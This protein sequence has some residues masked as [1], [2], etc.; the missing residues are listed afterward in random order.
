AVTYTGTMPVAFNGDEFVVN[1]TVT[2]D[3]LVDDNS[4]AL[5][6]RI[7][8]I[9]GATDWS[10][11]IVIASKTNVRTGT[12]TY[13]ATFSGVE[14][15]HTPTTLFNGMVD[16]RFQVSDRA[17]ETPNTSSY[18]VTNVMY[19]TT[20]PGVLITG[21][22]GQGVTEVNLVT[23]IPLATTAT[24]EASAWDVLFGQIN[25]IASGIEKLEF[26][27]TNNVT[28]IEVL[29]GTV[30]AAP[31]SMAWNTTGLEVGSYDVNVTAYDNAGNMNTVSQTVALVPPITWQ[32]Y[33]LVTAMNFD[34]DL[35]NQDKLYAH[36][37]TWNNELIE[38]VS[39][40]YTT[41]GTVW[42]QFAAVPFTPATMT[43]PTPV[44]AQFNAE[45]MTGVTQIRTVVTYNGGQVSAN[46]PVLAVTYNAANG[47]S[48]VATA[49]AITPN[50]FYKNELRIV[51]AV[52]LPVITEVTDGTYVGTLPVQT[53]NGNTTA[54]INIPNP[55]EYIY[56]ASSIN[57]NTW[58]MQLNST[59][60]NT[61]NIGS[62]TNN[63]ITITAP[64]NGFVYFQNVM[65]IM[66]LPAGFSALSAQ[67]AV[68]AKQNNALINSDLTVTL[69]A[70]PAAQGTVVAM[71][72]DEVAGTW[73][74]PINVTTN[75][76]GTVSFNAPTGHIVA[77]TQYTGVTINA[78]F[79]SIT[80]QYLAP[81]TNLWTKDNPY[82]E[83]FVYEGMDTNGYIL[84]LTISEVKLYL[85]GVMVTP[86]AA[87][88]NATGI[89]GYQANALTAGM[90]TVRL[91]V[92][93]NGFTAMAEK[94]FH[95][96]TTNPVITTH[97][98]QI[99]STN[100]IVSATIVDPETGIDTVALTV[101]T[102]SV[103][104]SSLTVTGNTYTYLITDEDLLTL[105][106]NFSTTMPLSVNWTA[107]NHLPNMQGAA[108]ADYT[109]NIV[110]PGI[111]F[112][113]F[114]NG[115]W[116]NPTA[117]TP[118]T[119][120]VIAPEGRT[121]QDN[122][123]V[124]LEEM[125][126]DPVNGNYTNTIQSMMLNPISVAGNVY[127]Y[128]LNF[129]YAVA[130]NAHAVLLHVNAVDSYNVTS[131]SHQTYG[132]D[133]LAPV[134]W[135]LAPVGA[136]INPDTFPVV[137]ESAVLPFGTNVA[138]GVGFQDIQGFTTLETGE[139]WLDA[140]AGTWHND[141]LVYYTAA[142]GI[143]GNAT[144]VMVT[145]DGTPVTNGTITNGSFTAN[146]GTLPAGNHTVIA[147][148]KDNAGNVGSLSYTFTITGGAPTITF[149]PLTGGGWWLN[150]TNDNTLGFSVTTT[151]LLA[152]GGVIANIYTVPGNTLLQ[153][154][155]TPTPAGTQYSISL[156]GGVIPADQTGI[157]LEVAATDVW[158][159][160]ST[161]TQV[162]GIDNSVPAITLTSPA[163]DA[164]FVMGATVNILASITDQLAT[165]AASQLTARHDSRM[166]RSGSG[167]QSVKLSVVAP[168][169]EYAFDPITYPANTQVVMKSML[170]AQYGT[171]M[172]NLIATDGAGNQAMV[173]RNFM[174]TPAS[175]PAVSFNEIAGGWLN[176][177]TINH[178]GFTVT[179]PVAVTV[180]A[181]VY[182]YPSE[183]ML[184]GPLTV[185][186][187]DGVYTVNLNGAM[188][189][190][191]QTSV[192][193]QVM[194][195]DIFGNI[196]EA[197]NYYSVDKYAPVITILSPAEGAEFTLVDETT[198]VRIEA[199]FSDMAA[200]L[201]NTTGSGIAASR[202]V[203]IDPMGTQV[204]A[205]IETGAGINETM[206]EINNLILG[207]YTARV[208]V[209]DI[210]GNQ[211][212]ASVIFT[213]IAAPLPPVE[214]EIS[215]AHAYP[216]PMTTETGA[217][218]S[219]SLSTASTVTVRVYDFAG[220]EVRTMENAGRA[221]GKTKLVIAFDGRTN[222]GV[223][224]ARGTYFARVI[225]NDGKKIV[226]KIV[227]IA[228]KK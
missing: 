29:I 187:V 89:I 111:V 73:S 22:T 148:V 144:N 104:M 122:L 127:S 42:T 168:D 150:S 94:V 92:T 117:N 33:A 85:D 43:P 120:N 87:Y 195:T 224:L 5:Q 72:Y 128:S 21:I 56:W 16:F 210:A 6:A 13:V 103:P 136:P 34:G 4:I 78:M 50:V 185:N 180:S 116:I 1:Y 202:M 205:A 123:S 218:F 118:L 201:K 24:I 126:N 147:T 69:N 139:W 158:G 149:N 206:T 66:T 62:V 19:D 68:F 174:V 161:S 9:D 171:Y 192:R 7:I 196:V 157:R 48:L 154:P 166:D 90:H 71:W 114:A 25:Q 208:T 51:G 76:N 194:V 225:A 197:N 18:I 65:P 60:L 38:A 101:G 152:Q 221:D 8:G 105:G 15:Y 133:Y 102:I 199:Q 109:V 12:N 211:A 119:F 91:L 209:W 204:G 170:A 146:A 26:S 49:P 200:M 191:D 215:D 47:G 106:Y 175:G 182:T 99:T 124:T 32:P 214:L 169:G 63:G 160:T 228:I 178:L 31:Y 115:W 52:N 159:G 96:D 203:V 28:G 46:K 54:F 181:N 100:R 189:P 188:I 95:V 70:T 153:G 110:A 108:S 64:A 98:S 93:Q 184:M 79:R 39:F 140:V 223:K 37:D 84:P 59:T 132:I 130:P 17:E 27:Y 88:N 226:E 137:Y 53:V 57:Y 217:N 220:R 129:G 86:T 162:Y 113:G 61:T 67:H 176:S 11:P 193:L 97:G 173:S 138:L 40:E 145:L 125:I 35:A 10:R 3:D 213:V 216:N 227:K 20:D 198:K 135:A 44:V 2:S 55:G 142:S 41:N 156:L 107:N 186:P 81:T 121:I 172:I 131:L 163:E 177:V 30:T 45:L 80:P 190:A 167:I 77:V 112:T 219:V 212:Q 83:F 82:I 151:N 14:I 36:V 141:Y 183:A 75:T 207:A 134:V 179:S 165:K 23:N 143:T 164:Q 74:S 58:V 222:D 155:I